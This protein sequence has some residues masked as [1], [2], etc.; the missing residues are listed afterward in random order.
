MKEKDGRFNEIMH[1]SL[2]HVDVVVV[3]HFLAVVVLYINEEVSQLIL[4]Q[5]E[6]RDAV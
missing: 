5:G 6:T 3:R 2:T 4:W 1:D